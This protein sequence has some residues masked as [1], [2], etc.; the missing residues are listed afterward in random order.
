MKTFIIKL[1]AFTL[2]IVMILSAIKSTVPFY[3]GQNQKFKLL[4]N[5]IEYFLE[6]S[7]QYDVLFFGSSRTYRHIDPL[8][9]D[10]ITGL[11][12]FNFGIAGCS[13]LETHYLIDNLFKSLVKKDSLIIFLQ[14]TAPWPIKDDN[15]HSIRSKYYLDIKRLDMALSYYWKKRNYHQIYNY[16]VSYLENKLC[17]GELKMIFFYLTPDHPRKNEIMKCYDEI[18]INNQGFLSIDQ[19]ISMQW[20]STGLNKRRSKYLEKIN[21]AVDNETV[22][23]QKE[24]VVISRLDDCNINSYNVKISFYKIGEIRLRNEFYFDKVHFNLKGGRFFTEKIAKEFI[25]D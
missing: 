1:C 8:L 23:T 7:N 14:E 2:F 17:I 3:W 25:K 11:K 22:L 13:Y 21:Q 12:S 16:L 5:K 6:N 19:Q 24:E 10:S 15:L 20:S 18:I 9:F 4:E